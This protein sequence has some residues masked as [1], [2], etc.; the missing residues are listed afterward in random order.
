MVWFPHPKS[1]WSIGRVNKINSDGMIE[2]LE[3]TD[4][5]VEGNGVIFRFE[6][7]SH[8][9]LLTPIIQTYLLAK[10]EIRLLLVSNLGK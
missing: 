2:V 8:N 3:C 1:V 6:I 4:E 5:G 10:E 7:C 9:V